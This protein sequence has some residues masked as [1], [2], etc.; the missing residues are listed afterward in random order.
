V[1]DQNAHVVVRTS[2]RVSVAKAGRVEEIILFGNP[3][4]REH[5]EEALHR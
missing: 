3:D 1:L 5:H 2:V 4:A